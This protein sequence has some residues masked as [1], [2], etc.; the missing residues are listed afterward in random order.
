[1]NGLR[2][3]GVFRDAARY[4]RSPLLP[5]A[6]LLTAQFC[7]HR[8]A[9]H[10]HDTFVIP[11]IE[12]GAQGYRYRGAQRVAGPGAIATINPGEI[13]TG[14]R[15][16]VEGWAY[17]VFYP[18]VDLLRRLASGFAGRPA[19]EPRFPDEVIVDREVARRLVEA[20]RL[21]EAGGD[22]LIAD[23]ALARAFGLLL[24]RHSRPRLQPAALRTDDHR[25]A[26]MKARLAAD[27]SSALTLGEL[28][29]AVEL[30]PFH[31]LRL[32]S[33]VVGMPPHAWRTQLRLQRAVDLLRRG[34]PVGE[35]AAECG[36][37]DQSHFTRHFRR[38][39]GVPPGRWRGAGN[40]PR[41]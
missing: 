28:A 20:H 30:S 26:A 13:H 25:V 41:Q 7:E 40:A 9:P 1:M 32:F 38:A 19:E 37:A 18:P 3:E 14:E 17:R 31:A 34:L 29:A 4:W 12:A 10:W 22:H 11:V 39:Y 2:K 27:P 15:A 8:F 23:T 16:A 5:D 24:S 6:E 35:A 33:R 36:Y 21:L